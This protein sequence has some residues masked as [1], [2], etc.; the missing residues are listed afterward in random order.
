MIG[1]LRKSDQTD[2]KNVFSDPKENIDVSLLLL[3]T[4]V[5]D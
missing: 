2:E 3:V 5:A 4:L 1:M